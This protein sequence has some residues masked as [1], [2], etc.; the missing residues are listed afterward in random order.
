MTIP[1]PPNTNTVPIN[2]T[3]STFYPYL[4]TPIPYAIITTLKELIF[5]NAIFSARF[6]PKVKQISAISKN[7]P[8]QIKDSYIS[9]A[10]RF[11]GNK[12]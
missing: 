9:E 10:G 12:M 7:T 6:S 5:V 1:T 2:E 11:Y 3:A 8:I 4:K